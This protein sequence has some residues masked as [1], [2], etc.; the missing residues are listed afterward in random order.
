[1]KILLMAA[2]CLATLVIT[3]CSSTGG[4]GAGMAP[5]AA[6]RDRTTE[7]DESA[8]TRRARVRL[9]LA[10]AYYARGQLEVALDEVKLALSVDPKLV[11]ALNLRGLIYTGLADHQLAEDSFNRALQIAPRD[12]DTMQNYGWYLCQRLRFHEADVYFDRVLAAPLYNNAQR[13]LV[14]KGV[15]QSR[16]GLLEIAEQTIMKAH[17]IDPSNLLASLSLAE[18]LYKRGQYERARF[19]IRRI[20]LDP[21]MATPQSLWI[22]A[23]IEKKLNNASGVAILGQQLRDRFPRATETIAFEKGSFDD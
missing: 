1:M 11:P 9:E 5:S 2:S 21:D 17:A 4:D 22:A 12:V 23:R 14:A 18:V 15:C 13:T 19:Y 6:Q 16:N 3:A 8:E 10:A 7:S 20:N